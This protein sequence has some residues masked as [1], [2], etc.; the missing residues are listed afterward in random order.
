MLGNFQ[1]QS[2]TSLGN[3]DLEGIQNFGK[4][5]GELNIHYSTDNGGDLTSAQG[6]SGGAVCTDTR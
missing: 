4:L 5:V 6:T 2:L 1:D 3:F